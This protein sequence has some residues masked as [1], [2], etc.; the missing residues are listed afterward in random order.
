ME[1]KRYLIW[2]LVLIIPAGVVFGEDRR[3]R[4]DFID[5]MRRQR[6]EGG[7]IDNIQKL[8]LKDFSP[9]EEV[10]GADEMTWLK[11]LDSN[12]GTLYQMNKREC[13][14]FLA[15]NVDPRTRSAST[16][17]CRKCGEK[18]ILTRNLFFFKGSDKTAFNDT[19]PKCGFRDETFLSNTPKNRPTPRIYRPQQPVMLDAPGAAALKGLKGVRVFLEYIDH[20]E[21]K[22]DIVDYTIKQLVTSRLSKNEITVLKSGGRVK[23]QGNPKLVITI[24]VDVVD[25]RQLA[26]A[27]IK[28]ELEEILL[29]QRSPGI[30]VRGTTWKRSALKTGHK[31]YIKKYI[32]DYVMDVTEAFINDYH[33]AN[34]KRKVKPAKLELLTDQMLTGTVKHLRFEGGFYGIVGSDGAKYDPVNLPK[35]F[36]KDGLQVR[37]QVKEKKGMMGIHMWGKIVEIVKIEH[38][39]N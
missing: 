5:D 38:D 34:P 36:Q 27:A 24:E 8:G 21:N 25:N 3:N 23:T 4:E 32:R 19:C 26:V 35:E 10:F 31:D 33:K 6:M 7:V 28:F 11:S 18:S 1:A 22:F 37:F 12:C 14:K 15:E 2:C 16:L 9:L 39:R 17:V 20:D 30:A 13:Y 29:L